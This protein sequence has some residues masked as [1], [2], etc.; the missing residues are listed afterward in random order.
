MSVHL[1]LA[2]TIFILDIIIR[3][4]SIFLNKPTVSF[5]Q[6][7]T[8]MPRGD[9]QLVRDD[10]A[11]EVKAELLSSSLGVT[12]PPSLSSFIPSFPPPSHHPLLHL[13]NT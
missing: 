6:I 10:K 9:N 7:E 5:L 8:L 3:C 12:F 11:G 2:G 4:F 1:S 13:A